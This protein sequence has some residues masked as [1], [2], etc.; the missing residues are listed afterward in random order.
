MRR[1]EKEFGFYPRPLEVDAGHVSIRPLADFDET[2]EGAR[3]SDG[4]HDGWIHAGL[5]QSRDLLSGQV[6]ERPYRARV[7]GL[8]KT[9]IA[10]V[11]ATAGSRPLCIGATRVEEMRTRASDESR[12]DGVGAGGG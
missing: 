3:S 10:G 1:I 9:P 4:V 11:Q 5:Q 6:R 12:R 8:G 2:V 7:F